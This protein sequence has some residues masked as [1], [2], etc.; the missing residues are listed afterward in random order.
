MSY[1]SIL[2]IAVGLGM[3]AFS[4][5]VGVGASVR[6]VSWGA[7]FRLSSYFGLFQF[8]MP[9]AGWFA[10]VSA[11]SIIA[12]YDHW[13]AFGLLVLVGGKMIIESFTGETKVHTT[14]PTRGLTVA[15]LS[16]AT[17]ID[18]LAV[19]FSFALLQI[20]VFY[21][22]IVIGIVAFLMTMCGMLFGEKLG[23]IFGKKVEIFGGILLI[24]IGVKILME[25]MA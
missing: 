21:P 12:G 11:A 3:D 16:V 7:V 6:A 17:S 18:A 14:D 1:L 8:F 15:I 5:A 24:G 2:I 25:H 20:P 22:S 13:I 10:G 19:G 9:V 23:A 4:V